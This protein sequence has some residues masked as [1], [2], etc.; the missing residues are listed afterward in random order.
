MSDPTKSAPTLAVL[1]ARR[2]EI[3]VL[4]EHY[5]TS[6]LRVFGSVTRGD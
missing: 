4:A 1:R 5:G 2:D 6:N 3:L